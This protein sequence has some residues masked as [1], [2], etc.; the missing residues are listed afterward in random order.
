MLAACMLAAVPRP[1]AASSQL[2]PAAAV[3]MSHQLPLVCRGFTSDLMWDVPAAATLK[4]QD[5]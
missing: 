4:G 3:C 2:P 1:E 5:S